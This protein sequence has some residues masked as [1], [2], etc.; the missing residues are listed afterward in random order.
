M[1]RTVPNTLVEAHAG[2][3]YR[4]TI[5]QRPRRVRAVCAGRD[6]ADSTRALVLRETRHRPVYY[7]PREDV[8]MD[9]LRATQHR[10]H[11]PFRGNASYW[12][13]SVADVIL[14]NAAWSY[15]DPYGDAEAIRGHIAFF[16]DGPVTIEEDAGA[17]AANAAEGSS[18]L[19]NPLVPWLV[20]EA[21]HAATTQDLV[22]RFVESARA[23][24]VPLYR[25]AIVIRTLH[26][27]LTG[28]SYVWQCETAEV[29]ESFVAHEI[30]HSEQYLNSPLVPIFEGA[31][32]IRRRLDGPD[33][34]LDFAILRQLHEEGVTD[35][36]AMPLLFSD[37]QINA[38][39]LAT[40]RAGGFTTEHLGHLYEILPTL[41]RLF[42]VHAL[43]NT[44]VTLLET[45]LGKHSGRRVLNGHVKRGDGED[46]HA[47]IWFC[48]LRESTA[49][50]DSM[51]R[52]HFL[53]LLNRFFDCVAGAVMDHDGEVLRFV[54]DAALAIFP[55]ERLPASDVAGPAERAL[56]P[57]ARAC[58]NAIAAA[59]EA[60]RRMD[61]DNAMRTAAGEA[62]LRFGI[63]LHLGD[64]TYGNIGTATRLE[65]TVIGSAANEAARIEAL[66]KQL[67]EPV[68][69]S[70]EFARNH[71]GDWISLGKHRLRG[72]AEPQEL[73]SL[74]RRD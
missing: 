3:H 18:T 37:G 50:A 44:S 19:T 34:R 74:P 70:A 53:Q 30:L 60:L 8:R 51:S 35:Y 43:R 15:E 16:T 22:A 24:D 56:S 72:I 1:T 49:L 6:I 59:Y 27:Q 47:V 68:L 46:I 40:Q 63:A 41:S 31:G 2:S 48:D 14:D 55:I 58:T 39:T 71:P 11:C 57:T 21:W 69:L 42:E 73:F 9:L 64:V 28:A 65:F 33:P 38:L 7:F 12:S 10:T 26:P 45:Y 54:G 29:K 23:A 4:I 17:P 20:R 36:V 52:E 62:P 32:G 13:L 67:G 61:A 5:E 25:L 66:C